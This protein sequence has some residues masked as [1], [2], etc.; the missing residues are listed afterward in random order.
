L[1]NATIPSGLIWPP[2]DGRL[3]LQQALV[4]RATAAQFDAIPDVEPDRSSGWSMHSRPQDVFD[5]QQDGRS[6]LTSWARL[7]ARNGEFLSGRRCLVL[8]PSGARWRL[9][10]ILAKRPSLL[11]DLNQHVATRSARELA[12]R[13]LGAA[14][15]LLSA[16]GFRRATMYLPATLATI[17]IENAKPVFVA[18]APGFDVERGIAGRESSS[19]GEHD[20]LSQL[21]TWMLTSLMTETYR[22]VV[23]SL[24][25]RRPEM[26]DFGDMGHRLSL[27]LPTSTE[28]A[29]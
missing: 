5:S 19:A 18:M 23:A 24:Q 22:E 1:P 11:D 28:A 26:R 15:A 10:Q 29:R 13:I 14:S 12:A 2:V 25:E 17:G 20:T 8:S 7:H 4:E 3:Y 27:L 9:W 21:S 6:A 16:G